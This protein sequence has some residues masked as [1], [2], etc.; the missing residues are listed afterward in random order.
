MGREKSFPIR[1]RHF[2]HITTKKGERNFFPLELSMGLRNKSIVGAGLDAQVCNSPITAQQNPPLFNCNC[3]DV[4]VGM[5][6]DT[7]I[8]GSER[9][10]R[11]H[12]L[13]G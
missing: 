12:K 13:R 7:Q 11:L 5:G 8:S 10:L 3:R 1:E 4:I 9:L 2:T 6:L